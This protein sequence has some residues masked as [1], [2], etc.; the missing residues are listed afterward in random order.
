MTEQRTHSS[1]TESVLDKDEILRRVQRWRQ[2]QVSW[3]RHLH[4]YPE[5]SFHEHKTTLFLAETSHKLGLKLL[6]T[7]LKTGLV[8]ELKGPRRGPTIAI[9]TDI[10][11]LPVKEQTGL[12][13]KSKVDG[14]MHACGHD[15]HMAVTLA[16]AAV[17]AG[18]R[19]RLR[20]NVRFLFQPGEE[21]PPGG[22]RPMIENGA[23][24]SVSMIFGLH[25][26]PQIA[27]GK[28]GLRDG[29]SM[30]SVT[31]IDLEVHGRGGHAA[32]PHLAVD[33]IVVAAE[34]VDSVQKVVSREIDPSLPVAVTFGMIQGGT[35][36]NV[37]A[38]HVKLTGTARALSARTARALPRLIKRA[39]GAVCRG[40]GAKLDMVTIPGYP[41]LK[42]DPAVNRILARNFEALFGKGRIVE[43]QPFLGGEDFACYLEKVPGAMFRLGV[44]NKKIKADKPWHSPLFVAD[45]RA[46]T[47]GTAL[48]VAAVLDSLLSGLK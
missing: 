2:R 35:A 17:L 46:M 22:A 15:V 40:R 39:A 14:C 42:N 12:A 38:D 30:G 23:L 25:T 6:P 13:F 8:A 10:D 18:M 48:L 32:R 24:D 7:R 31:D 1:I 47:Y 37:I 26:D 4:Q 33:A 28:I 5:L 43:T 41:V 9:R 21:T 29:I 44:M 11:A 36:R 3:R 45:E 27:T 16:S 20:G 34:I 19:D